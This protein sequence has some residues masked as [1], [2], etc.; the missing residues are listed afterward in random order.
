MRL[1]EED[2]AWLTLSRTPGLDA[3]M[4]G[5]ALLGA[6]SA[7]ALVC[8]GDHSR[9]RAGLSPAARE[10]LRRAAPATEAELRWLAGPLHRLIPVTDPKYPKLLRELD[11]HPVALYAAGNLDALGEPQL[12]A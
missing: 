9:E 8:A 10:Y 3:R 11:D 12:A 2:L 4:L 6:G 5:A 7:A 1:S